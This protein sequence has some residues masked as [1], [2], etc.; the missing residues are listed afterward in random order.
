M[1]PWPTA[2]ASGLIAAALL[3]SASSEPYDGNWWKGQRIRRQ[4]GFIAGVD[5]C[6]SF[7]RKPSVKLHFC[8]ISEG[9]KLLNDFYSVESQRGAAVIEAL[10]MIRGQDCDS[11]PAP[12]A[13]VWSEPHGYY[14]GMWW[15]GSPPGDK[16][17]GFLEGFIA[18]LPNGGSQYPKGIDHYL[19]AIDDWY[20]TGS[21]DRIYDKIP[22]VLAKFRQDAK[23]KED[24]R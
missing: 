3:A 12:G 10:Q 4:E 1:R 2:F 11:T 5:D 9:R 13:S 23:A 22:D 16:E 6:L 19:S 15:T 18:C 14:D 20:A 24:P 7:E 21:E 8:T 17:R